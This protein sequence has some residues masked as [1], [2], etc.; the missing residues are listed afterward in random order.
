MFTARE[1][2]RGAFPDLSARAMY[3]MRVVLL[4]VALLAAGECSLSELLAVAC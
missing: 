3:R 2:E 4:G 1:G